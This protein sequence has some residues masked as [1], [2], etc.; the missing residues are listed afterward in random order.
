MLLRVFSWLPQQLYEITRSICPD[1]SH[2]IRYLILLR[3]LIGHE[4]LTY[5]SLGGRS[6]NQELPTIRKFQGMPFS[7]LIWNM[8]HTVQLLGLSI[9]MKM[10][11]REFLK[12]GG[13]TRF[14][15]S[16][17]CLTDRDQV[18]FSVLCR[19]FK[20][21]MSSAKKHKALIMYLCNVPAKRQWEELTAKKPVL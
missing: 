17:K 14:C 2:K 19:P 8:V 9:A 5:S 18:L 13:N 16:A 12:S 7:V 11:W 3:V 20:W 15:K 21:P 1:A 6:K 10:S 4:D